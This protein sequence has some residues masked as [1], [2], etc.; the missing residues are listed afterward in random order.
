MK[1]LRLLPLLLC[2]VMMGCKE[3]Q[4]NSNKHL[5]L[6][7]Y[8]SFENEAYSI[9]SHQIRDLM[10]SLMRNDS[11]RHAADLHTRHYYQHDGDFIWITRHGVDHRADT[12]LNY[13]RTVS[14]MGF[15]ERRFMVSE[16]GEDLERLRTL[17]LDPDR[18]QVNH[19]LARLEYRLTKSYFRYAM[20][21]RFGFMNPTYVLNR[22]DTLQPNPYDTIRRPVR[23]RGLFDVKMDH[24]DN[25]FYEIAIRKVRVD[26]LSAFLQ[27]VQPTNPFY[28]QLQAKL[29]NPSLSK[30]MKAKILVNMERCRWRQAD[31]TWQHQKYVVVNIPSF[32]LMAVDHHD[33]LTMRI[34]CG[35]NKT[36]TPLLNSYFK[37]MQIN[38]EWNM[39]HSIV[40][41]DIIHH[42][43]NRG[44]FLSR[45]YFMRDRSTGQEIDPGR[46]SRSML[47]SG[48]V[49]VVQRGG[50]GN[51]LGRI[52]FRFDNNF[53]VFLHDTNS[54]SV[55]GREDRGVSHGC[56]RVEKPYDF[57]VFLLA[58]KNQR[59]MDKIAY[60][61]TADSLNNRK[62]VVNSVK[63]NPQ[64]P[65]FITYYTL[66]PMAGGR[67]AEYPDVYGYDR[68]IFNELKKY[69]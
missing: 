43:G 27:E 11:D 24:P 55:F 34:G 62:M 33:T 14:Q 41:H 12:L 60:S 48:S 54:K 9:N 58:E 63:L 32:H 66:Y 25:H 68:V 49:G 52:I 1:S 39:P 57:A 22:L 18:N 31:N 36:K 50:K 67:T 65:L 56:V 45:N 2:I 69:L 29:A 17:D 20:G 5:S 7:Y 21:Q 38:P 47:L 4:P 35:A 13:L 40:V 26:S 51:A 42:A 59:L 53:S 30:A 28:K 16:I 3:T 8:Q 61:M 15:N 46:V 23:Y 19:V 10:D 44:Y 6:E 64:V 37:Y